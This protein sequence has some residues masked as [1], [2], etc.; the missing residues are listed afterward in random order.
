MFSTIFPHFVESEC[1]KTQRTHY[2]K[3][4]ST[5]WINYSSLKQEL[6]A[7]VLVQATIIIIDG[8]E[9]KHMIIK[10][11]SVLLIY[12]KLTHKRTL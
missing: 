5:R 8:F 11:C 7:R 6:G 9:F 12:S 1:L 2:G 4:Q 10:A 3:P